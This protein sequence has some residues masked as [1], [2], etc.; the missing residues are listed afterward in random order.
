M[1][2]PTEIL[3]SA[4]LR[5]QVRQALL[6]LPPDYVAILRHRYVEGRSVR[7]IA[8]AL[9]ESEK[10]VE[11]RLHRARVAFKTSMMSL[12]GNPDVS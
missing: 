9:G 12:E 1:R 11:S 6:K 4:E 7:N 8:D 2:I 10:A 3:E 5:K